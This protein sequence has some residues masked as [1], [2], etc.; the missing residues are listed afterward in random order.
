MILVALVVWLGVVPVEAAPTPEEINEA[1]QKG[2]AWLAATQSGNGSWGSSY[3]LGCTASAVLA[4]EDEGHFPGTGTAYAAT[5]EAGLAYIFGRAVQTGLSEQTAGDPDSD[6]DGLGVYFSLNSQMYETGLC[7]MAVVASNTPNRLVTTG[8]CV[9]WTYSEVVTDVVDWLAYAQNESGNGRGGWRYSPNYSNSDNSAAQWPVLGMIAAEQWGIYAPDWVKDEL[10]L[11]VNYIQNP[12]GCSGYDSPW[13]TVNEAKTG[14]LLVEHYWLGD[15]KDTSE[16]AQKAIACINSNWGSAINGHS[17]NIGHPYAMF[18]IYKGLALMGVTELSNA[19]DG[20]WWGDYAQYM[21][22]NQVAVG[23]DQG[24]WDYYWSYYPSQ[25]NTGWYIVTLQA[26]IFP[27]E[28]DVE[29]PVCVCDDA[30]YDVDV[31]YSVQRFEVNGTLEI[32][33]DDV[34][35]KTITLTDYQGSETYTHHVDSDTPGTHTWEAVMEVVTGEGVEAQAKGTASL[36]VYETPEISDIPGQVA[37]FDSFD[38]DDYLASSDGVD[39]SAIVTTADPAEA[40]WVVDIDEDN[41]VTVIAPEGIPATATITFTASVTG[42][43]GVVCTDSDD[44]LFESY[45]PAVSELPPVEFPED[46]SDDSTDLDDYV[47]DVNNPDDEIIWTYEGDTN[48]YVDIDPETHVVT[49]T[50]LENW[51]GT[52]IITF[53]ATTPEPE[54]YSASQPMTVTVTPVND[55][56]VA[57]DLI[58]TPESPLSGDNL[59]GSYVYSDPVEADPE[60]DTEIKWYK[61]GELQEEFNDTLSIPSTATAKGEEWYF[62]VKPKDM[63]EEPLI[64]M[65]GELQT[66]D[67]VV[68]GNTP[69]VAVPQVVTEEVKRVSLSPISF[70]G[71]ESYDIDSDDLTYSWNFGDNS[72]LG[73]GVDPTHTYSTAGIYVVTLIVNDGVADSEPATILLEVKPALRPTGVFYDVPNTMLTIHFNKPVVPEL[74]C[75]DGIGM[76]AGDSGEWDFQLSSK[77]GLIA[78]EEEPSD[79]ININLVRAHP[80]TVNLAFAALVQHIKVDLVLQGAAFTDTVGLVNPPITGAYDIMVQMITG[81]YVLGVMGDA[82]GDGGVTL[83]DAI[84]ILRST[85]GEPRDIFPPYEAASAAS[86]WISAAS[87]GNSYDVMTGMVDAS[88]DGRISAYD[89]ALVYRMSEGLSKLAPNFSSGL[90]KCRLKVNSYDDQKL[91]VSIDLDNVVDLYS[92]DIVMVYDPQ[93]L[94]VADVSGT[95][96]VAGWLF[97]HGAESGRLRISLAGASQPAANGSLV[98]VSF[99]VDGLQDA[100]QKLDIID[101]KLNDGMLRTTIE[102]LPKDFAL[103]QNYPNPFNPETWIP[104]RLSEAT[105]VTIAIYNVN[106]QMVR[107]LDLGNKMPGYYVDKSEA[108]YWDGRNGFGEKVSSGIYF[109]QLRAGQ[110]V[111]IRKMIVVK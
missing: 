37:P 54:E 89:A 86:E 98:T 25:L 36:D 101:L 18:G 34:L 96:S 7:L 104:Y 15:D 50:A 14:A 49:F 46:T 87:P 71:S 17:G 5:V 29:L 77:R 42:C 62:T 75:F 78:E 21:V 19:T 13:S 106:G 63:P 105:D 53:T 52:E 70:D 94:T 2:L 28:I 44:A 38:L 107:R 16:R 83:D 41:V 103:M 81:G 100:I 39:W 91:E 58:I 32:Y 3:V 90:K 74:I 82:S 97:D 24:Y 10:E 45:P 40:N 8:Q 80:T 99:D 65:F 111:S 88:G 79:E 6:G 12:N 72:P 35:V 9:G 57:S 27:V 43:P 33:K 22:D 26:T 56:P 64:P 1:I 73:A 60:G 85:I 109:Y 67:P 93:T 61:N 59:I 20:D 55:P 92:A 11:W 95:S 76:E 84:L 102:G 31:T 30:G 108:A 23:E 48:I 66:S 68:I 51:F 69:P 4:F 47:T 110:N